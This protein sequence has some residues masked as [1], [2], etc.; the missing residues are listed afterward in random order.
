M[1]LNF[2]LGTSNSKVCTISS[3]V[4]DWNE[5]PPLSPKHQQHDK[6]GKSSL[7]QTNG[8]PTHMPPATTSSHHGVPP[9]QLF[10]LRCM[11]QLCWW[12][13]CFQWA[14][15][16]PIY[17]IYIL[18][19]SRFENKLPTSNHQHQRQGTGPEKGLKSWDST[20]SPIVLKLNKFKTKMFLHVYV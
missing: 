13:I 18:N 14:I 19:L 1:H 10:L 20:P 7:P 6:Y 11:W 5:W 16:P 17:Y 8:Q 3:G 4:S 12:V 2:K 9:A 15:N